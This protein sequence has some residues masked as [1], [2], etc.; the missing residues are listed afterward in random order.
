MPPKAPRVLFVAQPF[1]RAS[2]Y[3]C[4]LPAM[5]GGHD[6]AGI[7]GTPPGLTMHAGWVNQSTTHP[8]L[9]SYDVIVFQQSRGLRWHDLIKKLRGRGV[10]CLY[11]IDDFVHGIRHAD[12]HDFSRFYTK[13]HLK[14]MD[15]CMRA[16]DGVIVSTQFL[17]DKYRHNAREGRVWVCENG[18]DLG[19]YRLT[20]PRRGDVAGRETVTIMW[21]GATGHVRAATPWIESVLSVMGAV[22]H[23]SFV[24]IGQDFAAVVRQAF[25]DRAITVPF[26]ALECYPAAMMMGDVS[27][28]PA[29]RSDWYQA[30]SD[31]RAMESQALGIPVVADRHYAGSVVDGETGILVKDHLQARRALRELA[32]DDGLRER[33]SVSARAHATKSFDMASR[34]SSWDLALS[35]AASISE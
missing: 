34:V 14:A 19:R 2:W 24:S 5:Y 4:V 33:M 35:E 11:E 9:D 1:A 26:T 10:V 6:W 17:A 29:G 15:Q 31:L 3:R 8:D 30:K 22:P 12:D 7:G 25:P 18:L 16:C 32:S 23:S 27:I 28:A 21:A 13:D 20:R